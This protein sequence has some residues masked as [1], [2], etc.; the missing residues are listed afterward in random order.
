MEKH[1]VTPGPSTTEMLK[2]TKFDSGEKITL[3]ILQQCWMFPKKDW[4]PSDHKEGFT[5][6]SS[7]T[8]GRR[9]GVGNSGVLF[10]PSGCVPVEPCAGGGCS[11][12]SSSSGAGVAGSDGHSAQA[13]SLL[14]LAPCSVL[15]PSKENVLGRASGRCW[16]CSC[17]PSA[18]SDT[19]N[20]F[21]LVLHWLPSLSELFLSG[22]SAQW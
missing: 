12:A 4:Q 7:Q 6:A 5:T 2:L 10:L 3:L 17:C 1:T 13:G 15:Q 18:G 8:C 21:E 19:C 20:W 22:P 11:C 16:G 9:A 14:P